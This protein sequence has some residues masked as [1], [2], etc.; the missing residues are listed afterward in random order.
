MLRIV[1]LALI[2]LASS[3]T[4][5]ARADDADAKL[6]KGHLKNVRSSDLGI[7]ADA[8]FRLGSYPSPES[9]TALIKA[10]NDNE[11]ALIRCLKDKDSDVRSAGANALGS[12]K[13]REAIPALKEL[14]K[15]EKDTFARNAVR[16]ALEDLGEKVDR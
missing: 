1:L 5:A 10:L 15:T 12:L 8:A 11:P 13:A 4:G 2:A 3:A 6:L 16:R 9:V 14:W 7:R